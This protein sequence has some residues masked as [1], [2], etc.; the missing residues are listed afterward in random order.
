MAGDETLREADHIVMA[1]LRTH[2]LYDS[3]WQCPTV[4]VPLQLGEREGELAVVRPV[5]SERAMTARPYPL[6]EPVLDDLRKE[7]LS[8]PGV[9]SLAL[10]ITSKPPGT[11]EWE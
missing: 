11:I 2:D 3:I 8:L 10:D 4:L 9:S 6:P 1:A 7:I 5:F